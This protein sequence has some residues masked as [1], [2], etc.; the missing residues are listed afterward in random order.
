MLI[1]IALST[2]FMVEAVVLCDF[3][4]TIVNIDTVEYALRKFAQGDWESYD[5]QLNEGK[6][7]L[8]QCLEREFALV[9]A[10]RS[11]ISSE[12]LKAASLRPN[13]GK[14]ICH[15]K[16]RHIPVVI[17][18]AGLDFIVREI[19]KSNGWE[20]KVEVRMPR[21]WFT[22]NGIRF[23]FPRIR[24]SSSQSFKDDTV[25]LYHKLGRLV[26]YIGDGS[27]DFAAAKA[28][29][30]AFAIRDSKLSKL[31]EKWKVPHLDIRDFGEVVR[32]LGSW[33]SRDSSTNLRER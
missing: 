14:L 8:K 32:A 12:V 18:S 11:E 22:S 16:D 13:F 4:G 33:R 27:P 26:A 23:Q 9:R 21:T 15:C 24:F 1:P 29:D 31:C 19:V 7:T 30:M 2:P 17:V 10:S 25:A 3:D 6:I 5:K 20:G 28:A